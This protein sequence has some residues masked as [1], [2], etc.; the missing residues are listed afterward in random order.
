MRT[1]QLVF[2][3]LLA[4][5]AFA[6]AT[7]S[8]AWPDEAGDETLTFTRADPSVLGIRLE[9]CHNAAADIR[10]LEFTTDSEVLTLRL[11]MAS[12]ASLQSDCL[13]FSPNGARGEYEAGWRQVLADDDVTGAAGGIRASART[14]GFGLEGCVRV[15]HTDLNGAT[16][17]C[18][19]VPA[20]E[21]DSIVWTAPIAGTQVVEVCDD[22]SCLLVHE[23]ERAYDFRGFTG[24]TR[25]SS[26]VRLQNQIS[27][28]GD[29]FTDSVSGDLVT[30]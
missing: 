6:S 30:G 26:D 20:L 17:D 19:G 9:D 7:A 13:L 23:E 2:V 27:F 21:G 25:A 5:A 10:L 24:E 11:T 8:Y 22:A 15:L 29:S 3:S 28:F 12:L 4:T 1:V 18:I 16:S 14:T